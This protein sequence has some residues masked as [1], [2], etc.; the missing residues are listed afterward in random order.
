VKEIPILSCKDIKFEKEVYK[1]DSEVAL[2]DLSS[3]V[4]FTNETEIAGGP[5]DK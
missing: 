5:G 2:N 1:G 3:C 4:K